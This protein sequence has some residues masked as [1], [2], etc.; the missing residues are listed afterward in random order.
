MR[1]LILI[2]I[3]TLSSCNPDIYKV[4]LSNGTVIKAKDVL[5]RSFNKGDTVCVKQFNAGDWYIDGQ[6]VMKDTSFVFPSEFNHKITINY[7]I[8]V[9]K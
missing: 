5:D 6:G 3:I 9:I 4:K 7:K 1:L 2:L 8:G